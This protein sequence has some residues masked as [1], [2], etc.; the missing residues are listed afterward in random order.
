MFKTRGETKPIGLT[1]GD[2]MDERRNKPN[3]RLKNASAE[4]TGANCFFYKEQSQLK[5]NKN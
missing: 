5:Q 1:V 3:I 4:T 2:E